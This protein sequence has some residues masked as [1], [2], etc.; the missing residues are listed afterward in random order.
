MY[1]IK[2]LVRQCTNSN[3]NCKQLKKDCIRKQPL[4]FSNIAFYFLFTI[5]LLPLSPESR[6]QVFVIADDNYIISYQKHT[7]SGCRLRKWE[8]PILYFEVW[9][10]RQKTAQ[11]SHL[12]FISLLLYFKGSCQSRTADNGQKSCLCHLQGF[13]WIFF[14]LLF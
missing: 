6:L 1:S 4:S 3:H 12:F 14:L 8:F 11:V 9:W 13:M 5:Y 2:N 10:G 7:I